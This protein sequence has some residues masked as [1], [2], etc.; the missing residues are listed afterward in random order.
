MDPKFAWCPPEQVG[1]ALDLWTRIFDSHIHKDFLGDPKFS[2]DF[3]LHN[4]EDFISLAP[5]NNDDQAYDRKNALHKRK[6]T[7]NR[8]CTMGLNFGINLPILKEEH[9]TP[10]RKGRRKH[11]YNNK[12]DKF[13]YGRGIM[14]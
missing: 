9:L 4:E 6:N 2:M 12:K 8:A 3:K 13:S 5:D 10:W 14:G 11:D 7:E 1:P